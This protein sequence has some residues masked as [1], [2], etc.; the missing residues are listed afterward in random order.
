MLGRYNKFKHDSM[1]TVMYL[2][3][4]FEMKKSATAYKRASTSKTG[5]I[6]PMLLRNYKFSDDI[7]KKLTILP[8]AKNHGMIILVDWSGSMS[9]I[10]APIIQ[11]LMNLSWFCRKINI[12]FEVYAFNNYYDDTDWTSDRYD[13]IKLNHSFYKEEGDFN[14]ENYKLVNF[15]SHRMN[16]K[17]FEKGMQNMYIALEIFDHREYSSN[18]IV[19]WNDKHNDDGTYNSDLTAKSP[20]YVPSCMQMG[21]TPL[22]EALTSLLDIVPA[23]KKKYNIEK[24]SLITLT[25][26]S[27][28]SNSSAVLRDSGEKY[29]DGTTRMSENKE[30]SQLVIKHKGKNYKSDENNGYWYSSTA[31]TGTL[32]DIMRK[33]YDITTIGFFLIPKL[34]RRYMSYGIISEYD[35]KGRYIGNDYSSVM[36]E[37]KKNNC[38]KTEKTGYDD[39]YI[40]VGGQKVQNADLSGLSADAKKGDIKKLFS[41]SMGGR[42]K[43][44]VLLN[45][46]INKVA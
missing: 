9:N 20:P 32:L 28:N 45:H 37:L 10:V 7:F 5:I 27:G 4:E 6:D 1:K 11:Q 35:K 41:K 29:K 34:S 12:P 38:Y 44:R 46:F 24:M 42:L 3:K 39:Y 13:D 22:N 18:S 23:F 19:D 43:S 36:K 31:M 40:T 15:I 16:N 25:D 30:G 14:M 8:D 17:D 33:K 2:V 21:S 26:G